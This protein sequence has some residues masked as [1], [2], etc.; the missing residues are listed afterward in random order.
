MMAPFS[1]SRSDAQGLGVIMVGPGVQSAKTPMVLFSNETRDKLAAALHH[2]AADPTLRLP[3]VY[4][5]EC[6]LWYGALSVID[7]MLVTGCRA[8]YERGFED[9]AAMAAE[10]LPSAPKWPL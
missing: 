1:A 5:Q 9:Q 4:L 2:G 7:K 8:A 6:I 3:L 10:S